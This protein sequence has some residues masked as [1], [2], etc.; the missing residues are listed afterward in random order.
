MIVSQQDIGL[1]Q[2]QYAQVNRLKL[3][4]EFAGTGSSSND[5]GIYFYHSIALVENIPAT[6]QADHLMLLELGWRQG[7]EIKRCTQ[8]IEIKKCWQWYG[9]RLW[10]QDQMDRENIARGEII[11][12]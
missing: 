6:N 8:Y 2:R 11:K 5:R 9:R 1:I 10:L 4:R 3:R 12:K 7:V